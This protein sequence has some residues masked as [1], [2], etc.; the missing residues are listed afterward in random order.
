MIKVA[1]DIIYYTYEKNWKFKNLIY[2]ILK[3]IVSLIYPFISCLNNS[4]GIDTKSDVIISLTSFPER[5]DKV[6]ITVET[7]LNQTQKPK[8]IILWLAQSQFTDESDLPKNLIKQ[9]KRGLEV[10]FC[11]DLKSHKKYYFSMLENP[12]NIIITVD[13]DMMY[14]EDMVEQ[15]YRKHLEYPDAICCNWAHLIEF[16]KNKE[17]KK[18]SEWTHIDRGYIN[19][20]KNLMPVGCEA[21]LYPPNSLSKEVFNK[22]AIYDLCLSA[23]DIWLKFNAVSVGTKSVLAK[24]TS[25][26]YF[27]VIMSQKMNLNSLNCGKNKNDEVIKKLS[28]QYPEIVK[29][30]ATDTK[31]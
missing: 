22:K 2:K 15:L 4:Y 21:V 12:E 11:E 26:P 20:N 10:R 3:L 29:K 28:I 9:T 19:P 23:D 14:A 8:K 7:L 24:T 31:E 30:L 5:I 27:C 18:Y 25:I 17:I 13:D 1:Y 16:N 6:W